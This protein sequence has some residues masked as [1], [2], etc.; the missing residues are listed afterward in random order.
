MLHGAI[1]SSVQ[2]EPLAEKLKNDFDLYLLNFTGH[3][4]KPVPQEPFSIEMF[5][6]DVTYFVKK[7]KLE[8]INVFGYS[9]GGYVALYIARH[10]PELINKIFTTAT[11]FNWSEETS[12]KESAM[13]DAEK[14]QDKLP[15]FAAQLSARHSPEDW[16]IVLKKTAEMMISLG[17]KRTLKDEDFELIENEVLVSAGDRDNMVSIEETTDAYRKLKNGRLLILPG[18]KHPVEKID[19]RRFSSEIRMFF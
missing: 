6:D 17:K 2:L 11:K 18:T 15:D 5:A 14:I 1:G 7:N 16:R 3:G 8:G 4:G 12:L 13:L 10:Y 9:M 19:L